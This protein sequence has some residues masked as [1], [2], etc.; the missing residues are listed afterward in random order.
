M[1]LCQ[2]DVWPRLIE[3]YRA[4]LGC[5]TLSRYTLFHRSVTHKA[6]RLARTIPQF[7]SVPLP[8]RSWGENE[9]RFSRGHP[10]VFS[11]EGPSEQFWHGQGCP[12]FDVVFPAFPLP[13]AVSPNLQDALK[14]GFGEAVVTCDMPEPCRFSSLDSCQNRLLWIHKEV[15]F[16]PHPVVDLMLQVG[17]EE[18]FHQALGFQSLDPFSRASKQGPCFTAI[19]EDGDDKRLEEL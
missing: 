11:V 8:I 13:I 10:P 17:D 14:D 7:S 12:L 4:V 15:N 5:F 3:F 2:G 16:A 18:K 19:E 9:G 6:G 1:S